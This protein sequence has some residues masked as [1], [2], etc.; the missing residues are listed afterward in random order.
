MKLAEAI[1]LKSK[2]QSEYEIYK[3]L[4]SWTK[5]KNIDTD[6]KDI[7]EK[8]KEN[9]EKLYKLNMV[10]NKANWETEVDYE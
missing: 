3:R 10:I 8:L 7:V 4:Q 9:S 1:I 5:N 2:L 6:Y